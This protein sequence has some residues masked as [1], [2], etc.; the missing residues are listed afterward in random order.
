M[1]REFGIK[2]KKWYSIHSEP[3]DQ[4]IEKLVK[5]LEESDPV[6]IT[7]LYLIASSAKSTAIALSVLHDSSMT[8]ERAV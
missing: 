1:E 6:Y 2:L 3:Q 7:A 4:S 5:H 8:I